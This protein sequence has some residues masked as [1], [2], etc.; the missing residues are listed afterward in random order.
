MLVERDPRHANMLQNLF[1]QIRDGRMAGQSSR[2]LLLPA[3][4]SS[5]RVS[6]PSPL[7]TFFPRQNLELL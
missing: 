2:V 6:S 5:S 7:P 4:L 1:G 3:C